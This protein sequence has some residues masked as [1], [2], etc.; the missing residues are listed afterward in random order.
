MEFDIKE[1]YMNKEKSICF[2]CSR[3]MQCEKHKFQKQA[4]ALKEKEL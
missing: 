1:M 4:N 3:T 2:A